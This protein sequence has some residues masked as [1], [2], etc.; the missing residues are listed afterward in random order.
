MKTLV[1]GAAGFIGYHLCAWL[2]RHGCEVV[3]LDSLD[4]YYDV[5]LKLGRLRELGVQAEGLPPNRV[6]QSASQPAFRFVRADICDLE[7]LG[8]LFERE[9]FEQ[10]CN[11]AAQA[12]VRHSLTDPHKYVQSNVAGFLN[13]LEACRHHGVYHLVYAS[14]SSVYGLNRKIPFATGRNTD[15]PVSIYAATKKSNELMAHSYSH[16]Y[17]L[18]TTGLRFFTV[19]GPWG[20]PD[21]ALFRFTAQIL[22]GEELEVYNRGEMIRDFTY[23]DDVVE[24]TGRILAHIPK[25]SPD[26]D[27]QNPRPDVSS[28]PFRIFN[29]GN[30][31]PVRLLDFIAALERE[32]GSKARLSY[33][34]MQPGDVPETAADVASLEAATGF[35]PGT[36]VQD[37]IRAFV[38]WYRQYY[39]C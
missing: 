2:V 3:G 16:L 28:A 9:R 32:L 35:R 36:S 21:M 15:H 8:G 25:A 37:G 27:P 19:Y 31:Q 29:I 14:S 5:S 20:R 38:R 1:T 30:S 13:V 33:Q 39:R 17:G 22:K 10:V 4:P 6:Q 34:P 12:G 26:W 11:L 24:G 18:P 23:V 7:E